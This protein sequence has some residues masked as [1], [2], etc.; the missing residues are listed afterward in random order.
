[1]EYLDSDGS[2]IPIS[3]F[4]NCIFLLFFTRKKCRPCKI[5]RDTLMFI[6]LNQYSN[7]VPVIVSMDTTVQDWDECP[8]INNWLL[9]PYFPIE[10]RK[11]MFKDL[12]VSS[13]PFLILWNKDYKIIIPNSVYSNIYDL[14]NY[15]DTAMACVDIE[16]Y[17][18]I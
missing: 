7:I 10:N 14:Q 4:D 16:Q 11:K 9:F 1:M 8:K 13:I 12:Q 18:I 6:N 15:I 2:L 17:E 3:H 5:L